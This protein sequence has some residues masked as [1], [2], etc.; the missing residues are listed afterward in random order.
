[1]NYYNSETL[2]EQQAEIEKLKAERDALA[3]QVEALRRELQACQNVLHM[4]AHDGQVT[5]A[6]ANDAKKV[7]AATPAQCLAQ[8]RADA[9]EKFA[10][11][12]VDSPTFANKKQS[13]TSICKYTNSYVASILAGKE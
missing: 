5:P 9:V 1:M 7:L 13:A 3:A 2:L 8:V 10:S 4:L 12:L 11:W 6:Y